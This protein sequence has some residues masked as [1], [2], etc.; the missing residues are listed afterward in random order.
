MLGFGLGVRVWRG[1]GSQVLPRLL[2]E[3]QVDVGRCKILGRRV[4]LGFKVNSASLRKT[5]V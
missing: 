4:R 1:S 3:S 5:K 2:Q